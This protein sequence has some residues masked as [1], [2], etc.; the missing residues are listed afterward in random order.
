MGTKYDA[1]LPAASVII[2]FNNEAWSALLRTAYSVVDRT[3]DAY[4]H[5][6]LLV[7]D[8]SDKVFLGKKLDVYVKRFMSKK[9]KVVR[10]KHR[11]GL[12]GARHAG[13]KAAMGKSIIFL[14]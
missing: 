1:D 12:I 7:D 14:D 5:E 3:P 4:L 6:V 10:L 8:Y 2:I 11:H 9:V 13:A